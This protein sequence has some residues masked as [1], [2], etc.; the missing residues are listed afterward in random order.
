MPNVSG[1]TAKKDCRRLERITRF[2]IGYYE[3]APATA[4]L[5]ASDDAPAFAAEL[6]APA[7]A[8]LPPVA[9]E[10]ATALLPPIALEPPAALLPPVALEPPT[11]FV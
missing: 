7:F 1:N 9:L 6:D 3:V 5:P 2:G 4:A 11:T 8:T 10:P